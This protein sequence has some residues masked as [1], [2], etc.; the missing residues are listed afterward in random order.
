MNLSATDIILA[1]T[2]FLIL[3]FSIFWLL[4]LLDPF[5]V[6]KKQFHVHPSVSVI[7][8]AYNEERT[9][10]TCLDSVL[11]MKYP[12]LHVIVV[13]DGSTDKTAAIVKTVQAAATIP[14][15]FLQQP[16]KGKGAALNHALREA[17]TEFYATLDADS[18]VEP[19][20]LEKLMPYFADEQVASVLPLL[21]IKDPKNI[22]QR[23]QRYEYIINM[24]Y[25][26]LNS[27][28][29]CVHVTPGPF[30]VYRTD[31]IKKIGGYDEHNITEDLE[32]ALRLQ[33]HHYQ[34]VQTGEAAVYTIPPATI[35]GLYRQRNRWYKGSVLN[36][37][38]YKHIMFDRKY[39]D[40]GFMRLPTVIVGGA[41][42]II[43][44]ATLGYDL[45]T[46]LWRKYL[47]LRAVD[48]DIFTLLQNW[49]FNFHILDLRFVE[50]FVA[51]CVIAMGIGVMI[52]SFRYSQEKITRYGKT[53]FSLVYYMFLYSFL[54]SVVWVMI[55]VE[56][57]RGKVQKW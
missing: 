24:F 3:Y 46:Y 4:A 11:A 17:T 22:L 30:S 34:I 51:V 12:D 1:I 37:L 35:G 14:F 29:D 13:D 6:R 32:I 10:K 39:G 31:V 23:I 38:K 21:K 57:L 45:V 50:L 20:L 19:L 36:S 56:M 25:K 48:F 8:P 47:Q 49:T 26:M 18:T 41:L 40:F 54:L 42:S 28:L 43:V 44:I 27:K 16:N 5:V 15:Q 9:I 33:Q 53:F 2:Y 7:I 55:G 52:A